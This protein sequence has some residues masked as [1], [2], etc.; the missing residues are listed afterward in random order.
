[1]MVIFDHRGVVDMRTSKRD[2]K[3]TVARL[4][5]ISPVLYGLIFSAGCNKGGSGGAAAADEVT[6]EINSA[7]CTDGVCSVDQLAAEQWDSVKVYGSS[8]ELLAT[9][10][11]TLSDVGRFKLVTESKITL[12][13][14]VT[15]DQV[16]NAMGGLSA[17][18]RLSNEYGLI[19]LR[20]YSAS[21]QSMQY[22]FDTGGTATGTRTYTPAGGS[23][24]DWLYNRSESITGGTNAFTGSVT[25]TCNS[26]TDFASTATS[27][28][29]SNAAT[30]STATWTLDDQ[31]PPGMSFS[32]TSTYNSQTYTYGFGVSAD[33]QTVTIPGTSG[34]NTTDTCTVTDVSGLYTCP[35][36]NG[37]SMK[38][39]AQVRNVYPMLNGAFSVISNTMTSANSPTIK[40]DDSGRLM[41]TIGFQ[42]TGGG[43][44]ES[45]AEFNGAT[46]QINRICVVNPSN[47]QLSGSV[48]FSFGG[49]YQ[50]STA[51]CDTSNLPLPAPSFGGGGS[52]SG[53]GLGGGG[54]TASKVISSEDTKYAAVYSGNNIY[55]STQS[56]IGR[57]DATTGVLD[58]TF[59][60]NGFATVQ[61]AQRLVA[62]G[63]KFWTTTSG[64]SGNEI[65]KLTF[66]STS[67]TAASPSSPVIP[68][69]TSWATFNFNRIDCINGQYL[70]LARNSGN[71]LVV[72][73]A[74]SEAAVGSYS[75][76][77]STFNS[78]A[79]IPLRGSD[80]KWYVLAS[81]RDNSITTKIAELPSGSFDHESSSLTWQTL[82]SGMIMVRGMSVDMPASAGGQ[83]NVTMVV[84]ASN[85]GKASLQVYSGTV[86]EILAAAT[87]GTNTWTAKFEYVTQSWDGTNGPSY[88]GEAHVCRSG[89][90]YLLA[91]FG[92]ESPSLGVYDYTWMLLGVDSSGALL[93]TFNGGQELVKTTAPFSGDYGYAAR[94][95]LALN[96]GADGSNKMSFQYADGDIMGSATAT[97][98]TV[99]TIAQ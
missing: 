17:A 27:Q 59:G 88:F 28:F 78:G 95:A 64:M 93:S 44:L 67:V 31:V 86:A 82:F 12:E 55:F 48:Q 34:P 90:N 56:G 22:S 83:S 26:A 60:T 16:V 66:S 4:G 49:A 41:A 99:S 57:M 19:P 97:T 33:R 8:G 89:N 18:N 68:S 84:T 50:G 23:C 1:M 9:I 13:S 47:N 71:S 37:S 62:C 6:S 39:A 87:A 61:G 69:G 30:T 40:F 77:S 46:A 43:S 96:C 79:L 24:P 38:V 51:A 53:G 29:G 85:G 91:G 80:G 54:A 20:F 70:S 3:K 94:T 73:D 35:G 42:V 74:Q 65:K 98:S 14:G 36:Y 2:W 15:P 52:G 25:F 81:Q 76:S 5:L 92:S 63:G 72:Y 58:T 21:A 10:T 7:S 45:V 75:S 32:S 11:G